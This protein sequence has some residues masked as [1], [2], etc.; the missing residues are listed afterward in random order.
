MVDKGTKLQYSWYR[1]GAR[2]SSRFFTPMGVGVGVGEGRERER[3]REGS[4]S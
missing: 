4:Y 3:K 2:R 1:A